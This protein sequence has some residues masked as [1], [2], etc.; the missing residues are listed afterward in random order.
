MQGEGMLAYTVGTPS[1]SP[2][3]R[4]RAPLSGRACGGEPSQA[5]GPPLGLPGRSPTLTPLLCE[6]ASE[7][8]CAPPTLLKAGAEAPCEREPAPLSKR[9]CAYIGTKIRKWSHDVHPFPG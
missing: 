3:R 8:A 1:G 4:C 9:R 7:A 5:G 2:E 6:G